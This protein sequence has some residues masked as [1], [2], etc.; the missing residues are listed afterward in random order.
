M[1]YIFP[2]F[3]DRFNIYDIFYNDDNQIVIIMPYIINHYI[4][5][6][7]YY[8]KIFLFD[9]YK[10]PDKHT[11]IY[12]LNTEYIFNIKI[13]IDNYIIETRV[14]KYPIYKDEIIFS[15]IVKDEDDLILS[16]IK[17]HRNIGISRFIIYD[18]S[19][20][21]T[22][23]DILNEY[24]AENIVLLIKW[25]YPYITN[26]SGISGQT[27]QQNHSIYAFKNSKSIGLFDIDEYVNMQ[28]VSNI[29]VFFDKI[30]TQEK[31]N[32]KT[33]SSF[34]LLNRFFYNPNNLPVDNGKFLKIFT[35]DNI[36]KGSRQKNFVFPK[37]VITFSVH[38]V[39]SGKPMYDIKESD[40][41]F[42][43]YCYL[44]KEGRG[45]NNTD[46]LDNTILKHL[47]Y[48]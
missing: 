8:E 2:I 34:R 31:I 33:I 42:N 12:T 1:S 24:I 18:N 41:Y 32:T 47:H 3:I 22:L 29:N 36:T 25:N 44:N 43:H 15:T 39:T 48:I 5:K 4:I 6:Y 7:I 40:M 10:D 37:N 19:D 13:M 21:F 46:I 20:K 9:V 45:R 30:I 38:M 11:I 23:S 16:W 27:T 26:T 35:C 17:Y 14:N 28:D